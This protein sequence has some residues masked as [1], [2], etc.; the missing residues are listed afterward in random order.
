M[1]LML[2]ATLLGGAL[3]AM[4]AQAAGDAAAGEAKIAVCAACHGTDGMAT[5]PIYPNLAGQSATYLE[6]SLKAYRAGERGGGMS[7]MMTPQ[8]QSLSDEDI[9]DIAAY[10]SSLE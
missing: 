5:A 6:S 2:V 10:Y 8:A 1:K 4:D 3:L 9:A 7:A